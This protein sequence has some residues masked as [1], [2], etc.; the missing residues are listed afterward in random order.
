M[1]LMCSDIYSN[2]EDQIDQY[3][4]GTIVTILGSHIEMSHTSSIFG[5]EIRPLRSSKLESLQEHGRKAEKTGIRQ[6]NRQIADSINVNRSQYLAMEDLRIKFEQEISSI[7]EA[8]G[9][10]VPLR[11]RFVRVLSI[12]QYGKDLELR[13]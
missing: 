1:H 4:L 8:I 3:I 6:N 9:K 7:V 13:G 12:S 11:M 10:R 2:R 5:H